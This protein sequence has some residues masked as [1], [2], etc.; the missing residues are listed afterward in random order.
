MNHV[1]V[2]FENKHEVDFSIFGSKPVSL[3]LMLGAK[4]TKLDISLV[5]K[6]I[7]GRHTSTID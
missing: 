7:Q 5:E 4:Q 6:T 3:V 1:F 2:D